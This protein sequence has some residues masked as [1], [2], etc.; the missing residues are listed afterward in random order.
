MIED[1]LAVVAEQFPE[2]KE[3]LSGETNLYDLGL[4]STSAIELMVALEA[5]F[6]ISL[7]DALID[8]STFATPAALHKAISSVLA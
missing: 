7:P 5:R 1:I 6:G 2:F 8:E 3:S 4:D